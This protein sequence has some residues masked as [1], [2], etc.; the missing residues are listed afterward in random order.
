MPISTQGAQNQVSLMLSSFQPLSQISL[1]SNKSSLSSGMTR[2]WVVSLSCKVAQMQRAL[3]SG[4]S[5]TS[6]GGVAALAGED[7]CSSGSGVGVVAS[8][9]GLK[10]AIDLV[11]R[12]WWDG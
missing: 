5:S 12:Y 11:E 1:S 7:G 4:I 10:G 9:D 3:A 2:T 8:M 6:M